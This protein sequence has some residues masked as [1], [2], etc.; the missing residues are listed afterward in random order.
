M[1]YIGITNDL[2]RRALEHKL[3]RI[4]G[5]TQKYKC[6]KLVYYEEYHEANATI[7]REKQLKGWRREKKI[8][9]IKTLNPDL[10]DLSDP[11]TGSG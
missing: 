6:K 7:Q 3:G 8:N 1:I 5:F 2:E 11:S 10:D 9:L 4:G